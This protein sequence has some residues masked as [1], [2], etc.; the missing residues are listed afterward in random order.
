[1]VKNFISSA[2]A[3]LL[4]INAYSQTENNSAGHDSL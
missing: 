2:L 1:M 3:I 4:V